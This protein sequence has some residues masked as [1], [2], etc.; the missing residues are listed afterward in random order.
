MAGLERGENNGDRKR[1]G[2]GKG[3][4]L[5]MFGT[6]WLRWFELFCNVLTG[7]NKVLCAYWCV[8]T[9]LN[10][11]GKQNV[12][13]KHSHVINA[14]FCLK[15]ETISSVLQQVLKEIYGKKSSQFTAKCKIDCWVIT[16]KQ[17]K[18]NMHWW[19]TALNFTAHVFCDYNWAIILI[20]AVLELR[21]SSRSYTCLKL[22]VFTIN[23]C[24]FIAKILFQ[25]SI[26]T[27]FGYQLSYA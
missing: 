21:L 25:I 23:I 11:S 8:L 3:E 4:T 19:L 18:S 9:L 26:F 22:K 5:T 16:L 6:S 1:G 17:Q 14:I 27:C 7:T 24:C 2:E 15:Q 12:S 13:G 20:F 10:V